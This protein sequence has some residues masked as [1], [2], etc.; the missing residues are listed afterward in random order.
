MCFF[1]DKS[2]FKAEKKNLIEFLLKLMN[3]FFEK[4]RQLFYIGIVSS[5]KHYYTKIEHD[6]CINCKIQ[7]SF[8]EHIIIPIKLLHNLKIDYD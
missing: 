4:I 1:L 6:L 3:L 5:V 2:I 8:K 7:N